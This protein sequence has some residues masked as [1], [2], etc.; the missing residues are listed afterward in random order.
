MNMAPTEVSMVP[1]IRGQMPKCLEAN[2][3]VHLVLPRNSQRDT[4]WKKSRAS[5]SSTETMPTVVK[6]DS[7]A[8]TRRTS[9]MMVSG[10]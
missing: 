8:Q 1:I 6:M 3:G 2:R 7:V 9:L 4:S 5:K 10:R